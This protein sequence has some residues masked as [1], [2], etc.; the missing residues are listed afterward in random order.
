M[1]RY[2]A[3]IIGAGMS[4]LTAGIRLAMFDKKV[5][6]IERH[7]VCGGL[8]SFYKKGGRLFDV[9]L[10]AMTNFTSKGA[11][12][13]QGK[14]GPLATVCRQLRIDIAQL[15]LRPQYYSTI[16]FPSARL[17]FTN[18][19]SAFEYEIASSFPQDIDGFRKLVGL[20]AEHDD[21]SLTPQA[22]SARDVLRSCI[23]SDLLID[24]IL[25]PLLFYGSARA[26]DMD[27][28][29]FV[30]MFKAI[31]IDGF[32]RPDGGVR[33]IIRLLR[34]RYLALGGQLTIKNG[35]AR[36]QPKTGGGVMVHLD[37]GDTIESDCVIS[38]AGAVETMKLLGQSSGNKQA[39]AA[40]K[41]TFVETIF[42]LDTEPRDL[43]IG[44]TITFF[45]HEDA[46]RYA[47]ANELVDYQSGILCAPNNFDTDVALKEGVLRLTNIA[48]YSDWAAVMKKGDDAYREEKARTI[49]SQLACLQ[50]IVPEFASHVVYTDS[51]TPLTIKRFTGHVNG[52][53]Y[54]SPVKRLDGDIAQR[55][56][57]L[58]GTDQGYLGIVGAML[59]GI[60]IA[61][62]HVL[63]RDTQR[64][65]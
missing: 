5:C 19:L 30:I 40:G 25:C 48:S 34:K 26:H 42:C 56:V 33:H 60:L 17:Q 45:S 16:R 20:V 41:M 38:S 11:E 13:K 21:G 50:G 9:G 14:R 43:D 35:V 6:V 32:A 2:D 39:A 65:S 3:V 55:D 4:G 22:A 52:A 61:N 59:S 49:E 62:R 12:Q 54:G 23:R 28:N 7:S 24:M 63:R 57:F 27:F 15:Q 53:V 51:F 8:N 18:D 44:A 58:C 47:P 10:H 64:V 31:Y 29:Q 46:F 1:S 37:K 36:L